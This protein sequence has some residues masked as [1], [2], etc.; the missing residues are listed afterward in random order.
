LTREILHETWSFVEDV[1]APNREQQVNRWFPDGVRC[2]KAAA[3]KFGI[4]NVE[5]VQQAPLSPRWY[6]VNETVDDDFVES[7]RKELPTQPWKPGMHASVA[8]RIGVKPSRVYAAIQILVGRG[9]FL[10]QKD[11]V[12]YAPNG[13]VVGYDPERVARP[14]TA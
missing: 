5:R 8:E 2:C 14:P 9:V 4:S 7:V 11:G 10:N 13:E 1:E 12:L 3:A 6:L